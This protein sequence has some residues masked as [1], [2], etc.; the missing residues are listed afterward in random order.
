MKNTDCIDYAFGELHGKRR[1]DFEHALASSPELQQELHETIALMDSLR[2]VAKSTDSLAPDQRERL[3]SQCQKNV[4][5]R[6]LASKV[7]R[8]ALPLSLAAVVAIA[9]IFGGVST[10]PPA[11]R[12]PVAEATHETGTAHYEPVM[13][14]ASTPRSEPLKNDA[15]SPGD[16]AASQTFAALATTTESPTTATAS[17][18]CQPFDPEFTS[19]PLR[20]GKSS[21][22]HARRTADNPFTAT[23][24]TPE[25]Y[26]PMSATD[27][28][29]AL[30]RSEI[31]AGRLPDPKSIRIDELVNAF[32]YSME[33]AQAC[34]PV[35][36]DLEAGKAPWNPD[37]ILLKVS[38]DVRNPSEDISLLLK[39][40]SI[41]LKFN[42]NLV[43]EYRLIGYENQGG[44]GRTL[45]SLHNPA[46]PFTLTAIY[47]IVPTSGWNR[48]AADATL[49]N[50]TVHHK[51][52]SD[53]DCRHNSI[54]FLANAI[55]P[56]RKNSTDF[57]FAAAVAAF[58][59]K[60]AHTPESDT[61]DWNALHHLAANNLG[62]DPDRQRADFLDLIKRAARLA[63]A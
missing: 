44:S 47:E 41:S 59:M 5:S 28:S 29:Y 26:L 21:P 14:D 30:V 51:F 43:S 60:L 23:S 7:I 22:K 6:R 38:L 34:G 37:R 11:E 49:C 58:G 17:E 16:R 33:N 1:D 52:P 36:I 48:A 46:L 50:L 20:A 4:A 53:T 55:K 63:A 35:A 39:T 8:F 32:R 2:D 9:L 24:T 13:V 56:D 27:D 31:H 61:L 19:T 18:D 40:F 15:A 54:A 45:K 57:Q 62:A 3:I 42:P 10:Q 25:T 12:T